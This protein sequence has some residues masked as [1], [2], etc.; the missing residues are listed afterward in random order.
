[1]SG[2][3][4]KRFQVA[5]VEYNKEK[6]GNSVLPNVSLKFLIPYGAQLY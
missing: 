1:M 3:D 6:V 2:E 4:P 5:M